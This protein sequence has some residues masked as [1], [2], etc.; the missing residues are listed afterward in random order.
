MVNYNFSI[1]YTPL[2][3]SKNDLF[4]TLLIFNETNRNV[5]KKQFQNSF[6][7]TKYHIKYKIWFMK[8]S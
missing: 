1:K 3:S 7:K 5:V 6:L 8:P 4:E 2:S